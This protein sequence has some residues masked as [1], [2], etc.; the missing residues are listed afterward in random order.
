M[1]PPSRR[2]PPIKSGPA[3]WRRYGIDT[4]GGGG[5]FPSPLGSLR[6]NHQSKGPKGFPEQPTGEP[7][8]QC[9]S[10]CENKTKYNPVD[11][12]I[13]SAATGFGFGMVSCRH[14]FEI[15]CRSWNHQ[16]KLWRWGVLSQ[17]LVVFLILLAYCCRCCCCQFFFCFF[18][19]KGQL[20]CKTKVAR[21]KPKLAIPVGERGRTRPSRLLIKALL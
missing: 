19:V 14:P 10:S 5:R 4:I 9:T 3:S 6:L 1:S 2:P 16:Q 13:F 17:G 11:R 21:R 7:R 15:T 18:F 12:P 20:A 8:L